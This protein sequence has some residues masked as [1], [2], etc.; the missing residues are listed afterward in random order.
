MPDA[1][2]DCD[3][4]DEDWQ[5]PATPPSPTPPQDALDQLRKLAEKASPGPW[6]CNDHLPGNEVLTYHEQ[7]AVVVAFDMR[8]QDARFIAAANPAVVI[9]LLDRLKSAEAALCKE[10]D[11]RVHVSEMI[12]ADLEIIRLRTSLAQSEK[13]AGEL[14]K[15]FAPLIKAAQTMDWAYF[16]RQEHPNHDDH[17]RLRAALA[18]AIAP[19]PEPED[20]R[21]C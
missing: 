8:C 12:E 2:D 6:R 21:P 20:Q 4:N 9:A 7:D 5:Q 13:R 1:F 17:L 19:S 18:E 16:C 11:E 14:E 3:I 15:K 10:R